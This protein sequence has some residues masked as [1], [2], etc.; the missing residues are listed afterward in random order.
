MKESKGTIRHL[1]YKGEPRGAPVNVGLGE[2][3]AQYNPYKYVKPKIEK[4]D[5]RPIEDTACI[6]C[7][8]HIQIALIRFISDVEQKGVDGVCQLGGTNVISIENFKKGDLVLCPYTTRTRHFKIDENPDRTASP[9][10]VHGD[11]LEGYVFELSNPGKGLAGAAWY[12]KPTSELKDSNMEISYYEHSIS[13]SNVPMTD[14]VHK[15]IKIPYWVNRKQIPRG[16]AIKYYAPASKKRK[17]ED[18]E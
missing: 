9:L 14:A 1:D 5:V 7:S 17:A 16:E 11:V 18:A 10:S 13:S 4:F 3:K 6:N 8:A 2:L 12:I 15:L